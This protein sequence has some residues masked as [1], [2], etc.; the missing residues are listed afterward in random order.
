MLGDSLVV[1]PS[2]IFGSTSTS[3]TSQDLAEINTVITTQDEE[4]ELKESTSYSLGVGLCL[5]V[6]GATATSNVV[7]VSLI[8]RN[9]MITPGHLMLMSGTFSILLSLS[10][11]AFLSN[12]LVTAPSSLPLSSAVCLPVSALIT[13]LSYWFITLA[14]T[15]TKTPTLIAVLR[16]TEIILSLVT[17]SLW[18]RRPPHYLSLTGSILVMLSVVIITSQDFLVNRLSVSREK[19]SGGKD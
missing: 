11:T 17:E 18:W 14:V 9:E 10:S 2:F 19:E 15:I 4:E 6:A 12:R 16:S 5:F 3:N 1:Q 13:L 8:K 7:N